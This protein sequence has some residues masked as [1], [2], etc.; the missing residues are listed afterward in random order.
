MDA[1]LTFEDAIQRYSVLLMDLWKDFH[2]VA[3]YK[4]KGT[5]S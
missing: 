2:H 3:E 1:G 4:S 5:E